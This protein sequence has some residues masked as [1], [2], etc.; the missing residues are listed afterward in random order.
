MAAG[1]L[2]LVM[3]SPG[4]T[5]TISIFVEHF[6]DDLSL[7]RSAVSSLYTL[8]TLAGSLT[9]PLWGR[10]IDLKGSRKM[11]VVI[12]F[13]FGLACIYMGW[14]QNAVMLGVGF[15]AIRML[16]QGSLGL[17]SQTV[18]NQW[19]VRKRGMIMG[20]SGFILAILGMGVFPNMVHRLI[21]LYDWRMTYPILGAILI[22]GMVPVGLVLFRNRPEEFGLRPDDVPADTGQISDF[23]SEIKTSITEWSLKEAL[24]TRV[25][26]VILA[27][28]VSFTMISTGQFFHLVGIFDDQGLTS[29]VAASVFVPISLATAVANLVAGIAIDRLPVKFLL[30]IGLC[31]QASSLLMLQILGSTASVYLF[32]ILLGTTSG[33]FRAINSVV[34]PA[35]YGRNHLG[36]IYGFTAAAGVL[37]AALGPLPFGITRDLLGSYHLILFV[38]AGISLLLGLLSLTVKKPNKVVFHQRRSKL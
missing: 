13:L 3:T 25:F 18:I 6:I 38:F 1:S 8:G 27:S 29:S 30:I 15:I 23:A 5:Y 35:F 16:G 24:H 4:Q 28:V 9:L 7:S 19:W 20:I 11:V 34:W 26:W 2:G 21:A 22:L 14:V 36:S 33:L 32:G 10:Q 31:L 17:V 37:G 12:A